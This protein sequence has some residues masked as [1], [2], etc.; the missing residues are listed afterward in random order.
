MISTFGWGPG[1]VELRICAGGWRC[2]QEA[3][4]MSH[5]G[6]TI[7][8]LMA[9]AQKPGALLAALVATSV[10]IAGC[11]RQQ[12][13]QEA[14]AAAPPM[15][16]PAYCQPNPQPDCQFKGS[17]LKTVDA[18]EFARLKLAYERRCI[19]H[20]ERVERERMRELHAAGACEGRPAPSLA[21]SR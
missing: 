14:Q 8:S 10:A 9:V 21:A 18:A 7:A 16:Q 6:S 3:A 2:P 1:A 17:T 13:P 19:R 20:A 11:A 4:D 5:F 15:P 12:G